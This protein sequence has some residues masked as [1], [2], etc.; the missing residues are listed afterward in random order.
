M[1]GRFES[2]M[3]RTWPN[4]ATCSSSSKRQPCSA[5]SHTLKRSSRSQPARSIA[6]T[7]ET[8]SIVGIGRGW[9]PRACTRFCTSSAYSF[10]SSDL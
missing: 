4:S 9:S 7:A 6:M 10:A 8:R 5:S 2:T 3:R 1:P